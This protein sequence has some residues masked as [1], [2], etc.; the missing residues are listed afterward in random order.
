MDEFPIRSTL[1]GLELREEGNTLRLYNA[2]TGER[3][4]TSD[5][6]VLARRAAE[7]AR[8][9]AERRL[10]QETA[11]RQDAELRAAAQAALAAEQATRASTAEA[12]LA[13]LRAELAALK[14]QLGSENQ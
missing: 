8:V 10:E 12:E 7:A 5:E 4:P 3:L 6:E 2:T 13:R 11:A 14:E 9:L 1:L